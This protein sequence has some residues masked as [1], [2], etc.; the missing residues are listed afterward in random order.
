[1][2]TYLVTGACG[3][4][5]TNFV[6]YLLKQAPV[7]KIVC[8][9]NLSFGGIRASLS[10]VEHAVEFVLGDIA[11]M[12]AMRD[13]YKRFQPDF[14]VNFAAESHNDRAIVDSIPFVRTNALGA[15]TMLECSRIMPVRAHLQV[16]TIEVYGELPPDVSY[17][18]EASP[19]NAK[20]PYSASKASGDLITRAYMQTYPEMNITLTHCANNYGPYQL[21]EKLVP[22]AITNVLRGRKAP[23][24][25]DGKQMRDWLHVDDHCEALY[26]ILHR[27]ATDIPV[28]AAT[29]PEHLPIFDVS[30]RHE[31]H[32]IVVVE[33]IIRALGYEPSDWIEYV[34]DRP[35][36]D[37]RYLIDPSKLEDELGWKPSISFEQGLEDTV[38]WYRDNE[39]WWT[40][41]LDSKG[42][43]ETRW[44]D[45]QPPA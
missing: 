22:L 19:L 34:R 40:H 4:I 33:M 39:D 31:L 35:N 18:N 10:P 2:S 24:Y 3:F 45:A 28:E 27:E 6:R 13:V 30:A 26:R 38:K 29:H 17:F 21:P 37:R 41:V 14:V 5:G 25:G 20:T 9:D 16:S 7:E 11:D 42:D 8:V 36:H 43:L 32:N 23:I 15:H 1:M 44:G 12:D